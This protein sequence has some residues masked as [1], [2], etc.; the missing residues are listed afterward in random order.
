MVGIVYVV[1]A[2]ELFSNSGYAELFEG[3]TLSRKN[4][5][6]SGTLSWFEV[7]FQGFAEK[8]SLFRLKF[9]NPFWYGCGQISE[10]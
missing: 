4:L 5:F 10:K 2:E 3:K 7:L 6:G 9:N 1:P 8:G